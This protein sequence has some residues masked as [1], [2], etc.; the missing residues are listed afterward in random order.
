LSS[1]DGLK[2][3]V[4]EK[5]LAEENIVRRPDDWST[6]PS[7]KFGG[8]LPTLRSYTD[9]KLNEVQEG[10]QSYMKLRDY[11]VNSSGNRSGE[12]RIEFLRT[13]PVEA[14]G[15]D[16]C[17]DWKIG[18]NSA[19]GFEVYRK[20]THPTLGNIYDG[21][22]IEFD[23][24]GDV[25]IVKVGGLKVNGNE[26]ATKS[27][28]DTT[29]ATIGDEQSVSDLSTASS[30][31]GQRLTTIEQ[32]GY[33]TTSQLSAY[34]LSSSLGSTNTNLSGVGD[35][36]TTLENSGFVTSAGL[37][38]YNFATQGYVATAVDVLNNTNIGATATG[39][40][41]AGVNVTNK[42]SG[43]G[44]DFNFTVPPGTQGIQGIQGEPGDDGAQGIQGIQGA[45]GSVSTQISKT[46]HA[47]GASDY[48]LELYSANTGDS[49]TDV[50]LRFHQGGIYWGQIRFRSSQLYF[51]SGS[52]NCMYTVNTGALN[53]TGST[54]C[55]NADNLVAQISAYGSSQGTG[56]LYVGQSTSHGGGIEYNGDN[57][58]TSTGAGADYITLFRRN[59]NSDA[60]T[61]RNSY[62]S[63]DW[64]FRG[65]LK[66]GYNTNTTSYFGRS[67]I[68]YVG[69]DNW[70][71][72][73][74][75]DKNNTSDYALLH[76][77]SGA[78]V[79]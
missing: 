18:A 22:V 76:N 32:A 40:A 20:G 56:R 65:N 54:T 17:L 6:Y 52:D 5:V 19:C 51:T 74:H 12:T 8:L 59:N 33:A 42:A 13:T 70:A 79:S 4:E 23:Q 1:P 39:G 77:S 15:S 68:G 75:I 27:Y 72:F 35:R 24:D 49:N 29:F 57:S 25:N 67:A 10:I 48:H 43:T 31:H 73:A 50:S 58:P 63:N 38:G 55:T 78:T 64:E 34:A 41:T 21:N 14:F 9:G 69:H 60:W 3:Y 16:Q 44:V 11:S 71:G 7:G 28:R 26:V 45:T 30:R 62:A 37:G 36:V 47:S 61:A 46:A 66:A 53:A 2:S